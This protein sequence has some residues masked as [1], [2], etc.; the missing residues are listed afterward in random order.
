ML[1]FVSTSSSVAAF[2]EQAREVVIIDESVD[3]RA[4]FYRDLKPGV[5][6]HEMNLSSN[7]LEQLGDILKDY[8][9]IEALHVISHGSDGEIKLGNSVINQ[10]VLQNNPH[11]FNQL[12]QNLSPRADILFYGCNLASG[13][14]GEA[15]LA[16]ISTA[17]DADVAASNTPT[18]HA[19]FGGDWVLEVSTGAIEHRLPFSAPALANW[20]HVLPTFDGDG[21]S[22]SGANYIEADNGDGITMT[23]TFNGDTADVADGGN[24]GGSSGN[25]FYGVGATATSVQVSFSSPVNIS[26]FVYFEADGTASTGNYTFTVTSGSGSTIVKT[27]ADFTLL[28]GL[29]GVTLT[30]VDWTSVSTFTIT[31]D[32]INFSPGLDTLAYT[33]GNN[34]PVLTNLNGDSVAWAGVGNYVSLDAGTSLGVSDVE[35]DALNGGNGNYAGASLTLQRVG[36]AITTD[37]F[38]FD[39]SGAL[40]S[41]SG[42]NLQSGGLTFATFTNTS[43]VLSINFNSSAT[44]ATK[45]LVQDVLQR[46]QYSNNTP[47]ADAAL[48][49]S[50]SDGT[51]STTADVTVTSDSIYVTSTT[52]TATI[53]LNNGVSF[54]EAVAIALADTT[55]SQT[56]IL[57][58]AFTSSMSLAGNLSIAENLTIDASA[59]GSSFAI[60][61][62]TL[63]LD[64]GFTLSLTHANQLQISS[65]INGAGNLSK[66]GAGSL[67]LT[68]TNSSRTGSTS[69]LG[70]TLDIDADTNLDG[71]NTGVLTLDGGTLAMTVTGGS[72]FN[73]NIQTI[74]N[75]ITLGAAGGSFN[76]TGGGGRNIINLS[77][78]I[79]GSGTLTKIGASVLQL[80]GN[81][82][83]SGAT[84]ITVGG[85]LLS[86]NNGL[87]STSGSTTVNAGSALRIAA[88]VVSPEPLFLNGTGRNI[89]A[90]DYGAL[91]ADAYSLGTSTVS[92]NIELSTGTNI[93]VIN[94]SNLILSGIVSGT[95]T[96]T[97]TDTG[98]LTLAGTN[99]NSGATSVSEGTLVLDNGA[100]MADTTAVSIAS[101]ATL[102]LDASETIGVLSGAGTLAMN[103]AHLTL[104]QT[105]DSSFSGGITGS[106]SNLTKSGSSKLTLSGTSTYT[107]VTSISGGSLSLTGALSGTT[108]ATIGSG[109]TLEGTGSLFATSS[110]NTLTVQSGG[111]LSPG[112]SGPGT[113]TINGNLTIASGGALTA[114]ITGTVLGS[115]YDSVAVNGTVDVSSAT[116][117]VNHSYT[118]GLGDSYR[119]LVNDGVDS[120]TGNF[121]GLPQGG[122]VTAAGN[123]TVLTA[124]YA[125]TDGGGYSGGNEF[126]LVAPVDI[127]P[128][129]VSSVNVPANATYVSG[130]NL[131]FTIN[132]DENITVN[133]G[134][135]TPQLAL[136]IGATTRQANY[137]SGSGS[138]SLLFRYT[139]QSG[140]ADSDGIAIGTLATNGGT[141]RDG[142]GNNANLTLNSVGPTSSVLVDAVAPTVSSVNVPANAT[143]VSG[144]NLDFTINFDEN[145][146][147]NTG[148][149]TPQLALTIGAT[150]RQA[151]YQSGSGTSSLLYRYTV[152]SGD[153]DSDGIVISSLASNGG[154]LRDGAGNNA[155]LTLNSVGST[156]SVLVDAVTPIVSSVNVPANTTYVSGQNLDFTINFDENITV[157][158]GGGTP[159]LALII[160]A[161]TRQ[162]TYL[163][164]SGTSSLLYRYT[165]QNGDTDS[166]G[167]AIGSLASNGGTLR[168]GAGNNA[169]LT[170]NS[171]G[172]TASVLVD[173]A[174]PSISSVNVPANATYVS[175][176]NLDFSINFDENIT[177]NT[178][179]GT[180]QLALTI[181]STT[182]QAAYLSG[183]GTSSLMY[184]YTVQNGDL[185][186]DGIAI[187]TLSSNGGTLRDAIGNNANLT[188]NSVGSTAAVLVDATAPTVT[189]VTS[190]TLDGSYKLGDVIALQVLF[191]EVVTVTGTPQLTLETGTIDRVVN[192]SSGTGSSTLIFNYTVQVGDVSSD[193]DYA[194][195][196]ALALNGGS[197]KDAAGND[198]TLTLVTPGAV[199]S[200]GAN[201]ALV[202]DGVAPTMISSTPSDDGSAGYNDTLQLT[203]SEPVLAGI[204]SVRLYDASDDSLFETV[205]VANLVISGSSVTVDWVGNLIPT[206]SYYVQLTAGVIKDSAGNPFAGIND[207]TSLNFTVTH[208]A[209]VAMADSATTDEDSSIAIP[210]L[211]NDVSS[212][213]AL[214]PASVLIVTAPSNGSTSINN[215]TGVITYT[216]NA[217]HNGAD[218]FSYKVQD[219][220]GGQSNAAS[221]SITINAVNDAPVITGVPA[222]SVNQGATYSFVP[223]ASDVDANS[224]LS[225]SIVNKPSWAAFDTST[226]ALTG[227]PTRSDIGSTSG[228]G[229]SV[230]DGILSAQLPAFSLEV[231]STNSA[232]VA[233]NASV[234]LDEDTSLSIS[235]TATDAEDDVLSFEVV[236]QPASGKLVKH[237]SVWLYTPDAD[238]NGDDSV[239]FI[240]KDAELS[241]TPGVVSIKV[242]PVNDEPKAVDDNIS[243]SLSTD[244]SYTLAVL[245]N[246]TDVDGD[247]L[248]ID[249]AAA[250]VGSVQIVSS[251]L[252]YQAPTGFVGPVALRY[253]ISDG[254]KGR[255]NAKVQLLITGEN[256]ADAPVITVPADITANATGLFTQLKLGVATAVDASG[257]KLA[258]SLVNTKQLFAPGEHVAYW[259]ATDSQ[260]RSAIKSQKVTVKP[261]IS[262]S[263]NQVVSEGS[264]A[265]VSVFLNGPS[266]QYPVSVP[267]TV[268][269]SSDGN[270]HD[271]V[272]GVVEITSGLSASF[273]VNVFDDGVTEADEELVISLDPSLNLSGQRETRLLI[274]EANI[275]PQASIV[276]TQSNEQ[277]TQ[278]SKAEGKVYIKVKSRD[279]NSQDS[280][281]EVWS[282]GALVLDTDADGS[283]F[284]PS[285]LDAG[286]YP[287][288]LVVTDDGTPQLSTK[289]QLT[290]LVKDSL[291]VLTGADSDG[292]LIPDNQ[293]GFADTDGDGIADYLDAIN[294]CNVLQERASSQQTFLA[295]SQSGVCL[296][297]GNTAQ[298]I[299]SQG[300]QVPDSALIKDALAD[301]LGGL[302]DFELTAIPRLG[303]SVAVV[304][305]QARPV[306][307]NAVYRKFVR[308]NWQDFVLNANNSVM[309]SA[310]NSGYCPPPGAAQWQAGLTEGHWCVQ[311]SIE[312]GGPNDD[313]GI[314][315]GTIVDP[316]GVAV[317]LN[318]N[319]LPVAV[320]DAVIVPVNQS[321]EIDVLAN[322]TDA[323]GDALTVR[324]VSSQFGTAVVLDNQ[325]ISYTPAAD[326]IGTDVLVYSIS[327]GKGGTASSELTVTVV[328]NRAPVAVDD[329]AS[330]DDKTV[331]LLNVLANDSDPDNQALS[332]IAASAEQGSVMIENNQLRY[333]PKT[334]FEG[335]DTVS[336]RISDGLD[337]EATANVMV[338]VKAYKAQVVDN[339]SGG[340]VHWLWSSML[341]LS[342]VLRRKLNSLAK[343]K[344]AL[345][346]LAQ[347]KNACFSA[348]V[349][350]LGV[351]SAQ[352]KEENSPWYLDANLSVNE[353]D[354]TQMELQQEVT[355]GTISGFDNSDT[356]VGLSLGYQVTPLLAFELG[357][358]DLG[359]GSAQISGESLDAGQYHE[360]MK[361]VSPVLP[362][363][364]TVGAR[365]TLMEHQGWR[366]SVPV[367]VFIWESELHSDSQGQRLTTKLDDTDWYAGMRFDY[368]LAQ[369][370][371]MGLGINYYALAP[372]DVL[373]YQLSVR[374][375][376]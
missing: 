272:D 116:L 171:V 108:G 5:V 206:H 14:K 322:D 270:D 178:A 345:F 300:I 87:G 374:Y 346:K 244:N 173:A 279:V 349:L 210:V 356:G 65:N 240:A 363:G 204:G 23:A 376:F 229:I 192:Y 305:P 360:L 222:T 105:S 337:G 40:F 54:S 13:E 177:V 118:A 96:L 57:S 292:D 366:F 256:S 247:T 353:T 238:F 104:N 132:F 21:G 358:L 321:A 284:D 124:Y 164:G 232:P 25:V 148:G 137:Q 6:I 179:G 163:S 347:H 373:S 44:T 187:G 188:L 106:G 249:G 261:L 71:A 215:S 367:G 62:S 117:N 141:L 3:D 218:S 181:G 308:G 121:S 289:V 102:R 107:G 251:Q 312:D 82:S 197:I 78:V 370:W 311:L 277:R 153:A 120:I 237:G 155:N 93:S 342:L 287:I 265:K 136:T 2:Q 162:A 323:D 110:T 66:A 15:L 217:N 56:L 29:A 139:I 63:T 211:S 202:V 55:G 225:F 138:S 255:S 320:A 230:S 310:G 58:S 355:A 313:D 273:S 350:L 68:G 170:L 152:Q 227:T 324:Q 125:A 216:P 174:A 49:Y 194:V 343:L 243:Q 158:T 294:E 372:N 214:N 133:T 327:D 91:G 64:S 191:G 101:G 45:S 160:G 331:L 213:F 271:L 260:G 362:Q 48:R 166:D 98:S 333:T 33:M 157:N 340:S 156:A 371:S 304:I 95:A 151:S 365:F 75:P 338:S 263:R 258:V 352:A 149:G 254:H 282:T 209:P 266:P 7:G 205:D 176:Q 83:Y 307:T 43:G 190:S 60:A 339:Q 77:G 250:D 79:S 276:V 223:T 180:P 199:N 334:G 184:R 318:S 128:P 129:T 159:Q 329:M 220:N 201:K 150:G 113:I 11:L 242:N 228:I 316:G 295:E 165:V 74:N 37:V 351:G 252:K 169:N 168:D 278:V 130:Q 319:S 81:N 299:G 73:P 53:N 35:L 182:R 293:E 94:G 90:V 61:G 114:Q 115:G 267:Y 17:L 1:L 88:G 369:H 285:T 89:D 231:L 326:F 127:T 344:L 20:Q 189:S 185:D 84:T 123:S 126:M 99:T 52:D 196:T 341:L 39:T 291:P 301:N 30:P 281:T 288:S 298:L 144:Q 10:Q 212:G 12:K 42:A 348:L 193:L 317:M 207:K 28:S 154:T 246:D 145:I 4:V 198:A 172:S 167:I 245:D 257:K 330:T 200:L 248:T 183:S 36:T 233:T 309:S 50:L 18:G 135:G 109:G 306:P 147:V 9:N 221:V 69:V 336:Y 239:R 92:G 303:A 253:S 268:S 195:T 112:I 368:A 286:S 283:Y 226:G 19:Q 259:Q 297:L 67:R 357:Y 122:T 234:S 262:I 80:S 31:S 332:I 161:T 325:Q 364:G 38:G 175:G 296:R 186:S 85:L 51:A 131:D 97:K 100:A 236:T 41:V 46:I 111:I 375:Q 47:A 27:Q 32:A 8:K 70:G 59:A 142:A 224:V 146:T 24:G 203:F 219:V 264:E 274:T 26:S 361:L 235:F 143:Y 72:T 290:L 335:I 140:D 22:L 280:L 354:K 208:V 119:L 328:A 275:A 103:G 34:A 359:E 134:G 269:G 314:A 16:Y 76:P 315:N 241:S 302:F 86:H